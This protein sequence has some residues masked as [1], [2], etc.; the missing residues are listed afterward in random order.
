MTAPV[1]DEQA[2]RNLHAAWGAASR[3]ADTRAILELVT[4]DC[5]FLMPG[6]PPIVGKEGVRAA[7]AQM[8]AR[9][10][11]AGVAQESRIEEIQIAG[12]WAYWRGTD[13]VT[14]TPEHGPAVTARGFGMG[15]VRREHGTWKFARGINNMMRDP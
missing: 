3:A 2:I 4:D 1:T 7:F 15:I 12:D 11:H 9:W 13:A 5:V 8:F 6:A 14:I 10:G